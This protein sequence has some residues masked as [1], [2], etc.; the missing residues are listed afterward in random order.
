LNLKGHHLVNAIK[1]VSADKDLQIN[2]AESIYCSSVA[3]KLVARHKKKLTEFCKTGTHAA[4]PLIEI[5]TLQLHN[6]Y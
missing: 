3:R 6:R 1:L 2:P 5:S 4:I